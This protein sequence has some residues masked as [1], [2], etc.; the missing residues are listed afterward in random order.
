MDQSSSI[1]IA[2]KQEV[3]NKEPNKKTKDQL[4]R[5]ASALKKNIQRRK[6]VTDHKIEEGLCE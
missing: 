6:M 4:E 3:T 1:N 5:L 2:E